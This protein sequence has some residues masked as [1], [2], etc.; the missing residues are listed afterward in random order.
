MVFCLRE[1]N[2]L[3][4]PTGGPQAAR[5]DR[6][7]L[8]YDL[9]ADPA[10]HS[11]RDRGLALLNAT[12]G[13]RVL[14][15]GAGTG[16]ALLE[17]AEKAGRS[18]LACGLDTS[19]GM[20]RLARQKL[21]SHEGRAHLQRGDARSLPYRAASF[22]AAF[23]SFTLELFE[24]TDIERVLSELKRVLHPQGRLA[25]VCLSVDP[26]PGFATQAYAWLHR[27]FPHLI[28]CRP[29][30]VLSHLERNGFRPTSLERMSLWS[31][32]VTAL[33]AEPVASPRLRGRTGESSS[34]WPASL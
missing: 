34:D 11:A 24:A 4:E 20:L 27:Q 2:A 17:L 22:D 14:E 1:G 25:I 16:R 3:S 9:L 7:S 12:P 19:A 5:Y 8:A 33:C 28:D 15:I 29:I 32:P 13:E 23:V 10:E 6:I 21:S 31:L 18:G 30:D 26:E